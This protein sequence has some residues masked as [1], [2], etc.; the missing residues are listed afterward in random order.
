MNADLA[1]ADGPSAA[2]AAFERRLAAARRFRQ[3]QGR[4]FVTISYAQ[5]IDGSIATR[6][7]EPLALSSP[8]SLALT[9][10]LRAMHAAILV[11]IGTVLADNPRLTVRLVPGNSPLP[12]VLD[13]HFR[14]PP[15]CRLL[16]RPPGQVLVAG[17]DR[18]A[19]AGRP[20]GLRQQGARIAACRAASDGRVEL[21]SLMRVLADHDIDSLMVEGGAR[22]ITSFLQAR[23]ADQL[24]VTI[25]PRFVGGLPVIDSESLPAAGLPP[26]S[27]AQTNCEMMQG[28]W[29]IWARFEGQCA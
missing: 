10:R 1:K 13:S 4:P 12:V 29:V 21:A 28:D 27:L 19:S 15:D 25:A 23:L 24:I 3:R 16:Q 14:T 7:R 6:Q 8:A 22:V 18:A 9:H 26:C 5:S 17:L 20:A 11:G 2:L